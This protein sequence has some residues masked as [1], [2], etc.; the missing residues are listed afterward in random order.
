LDRYHFFIYI[1]LHHIHP[2]TLFPHHL[3]PPPGAN[4]LPLGRTCSTL[5]FSDFVEERRDKKKIM[6][7]LPI[8]DKDSYIR[9]FLVG[10]SRNICITTTTGLSPLIFFILP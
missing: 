9:S 2:P 7:F 1:H 3:P 10:I 6:T 8:W 5:L 4:S